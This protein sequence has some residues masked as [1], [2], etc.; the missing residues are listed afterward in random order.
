MMAVIAAWTSCQFC[1]F[2]GRNRC[3]IHGVMVFP[4]WLAKISAVIIIHKRANVPEM[5]RESHF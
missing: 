5:V 3:S 2:A 1:V 4:R